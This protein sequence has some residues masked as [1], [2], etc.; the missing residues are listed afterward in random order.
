[1]LA[2]NAV[3]ITAAQ[4]LY[5]G[6]HKYFLYNIVTPAHT[7]IRIAVDTMGGDYAPQSVIAGAIEALRQ[8]NNRFTVV[9]IGPEQ[10]V[11]QI[12]KQPQQNGLSYEIV[13]A[14]QVVDMH[15]DAAVT[16]KQKKDSSITVGMMLHKEGKTHAFVSAGHTGAVMSASTLILG[17]LKGVTR[18]T[19]G[20]FF[21][22]E[23][24]VSLLLDAGANVDCK[25][26][27]LLEFAVMGNV[28]VREMLHSPNPT[29]GLLN[30]GEEESKGSDVVKEAYQML[31]K[32]RLNFIGNVEGRDILQGKAQVV[33]C[34]G[35]VGNT[36]L[37]FAESVPSFFKSLIKE[38][39]GKSL[40][41]TLVG[42]LMRST[43][44]AATRKLDYEEYG[45]VPL[46]GVNGISII[47]HGKSTP[48]AIKNMILKAEEMIH[49]KIH[50]HI[51]EALALL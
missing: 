23:T 11:R 17:R 20:A 2:R 15:D 47:G 13:H 27:H 9:F 28:Y 31:K 12:L 8:T 14:S 19:I 48:K 51:Q 5:R 32:S 33:V 16:L 43:L 38:Y 46:L 7:N 6:N 18:P 37:K 45:G 40:W 50:L 44:L 24:G 3:T 26:Q 39:T 1:M 25:P 21:P 22:T 42:K 41:R 30:I 35:F 4:C 29:V 49:H 10:I 34:D 36:I